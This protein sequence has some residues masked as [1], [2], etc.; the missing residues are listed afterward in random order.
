MHHRTL[1]LN[2]KKLSLHFLYLFLSHK[3]NRKKFGIQNWLLILKLSKCFLQFLL[4]VIPETCWCR[5]LYHSCNMLALNKRAR[6]IHIAR[7][8]LPNPVL[9]LPYSYYCTATAPCTTTLSNDFEKVDC[10]PVFCKTFYVP[11]L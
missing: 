4:K 2:S 11:G 3:L 6:G 7:A 1:Y 10:L 5:A 9:Q 8:I